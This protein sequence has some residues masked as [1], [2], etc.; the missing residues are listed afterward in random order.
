M[1]GDDASACG[2]K[3]GSREPALMNMVVLDRLYVHKDAPGVFAEVARRVYDVAKGQV[4]VDFRLDMNTWQFSWY[5]NCPCG[6]VSG[7]GQV[8]DWRFAEGN[9]G[10]YVRHT[11]ECILE[12]MRIHVRGEGNEPSF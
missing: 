7:Y 4:T 10:M 5:Y 11:V 1:S 6:E 9:P 2:E 8:L 3:R 12:A